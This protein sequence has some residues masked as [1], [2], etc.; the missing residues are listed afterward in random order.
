VLALYAL[1]FW[2]IIKKNRGNKVIECG[3]AAL[4][5]AFATGAASKA[6]APDWVL[7][8]FGVLL[9]LMCFLTV[10]LFAHECYKALRRWLWK[11]D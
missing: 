5:L 11:S 9:L 4:I 1:G 6:N 8:S 3:V 7:G 10:G 2:T